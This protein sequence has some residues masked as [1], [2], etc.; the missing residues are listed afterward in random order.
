MAPVHVAGHIDSDR[1][2]HHPAHEVGLGGK[3]HTDTV[4]HGEKASVG[5]GT[6][7]RTTSTN[8]G[9]WRSPSRNPSG[10]ERRMPSRRPRGRGDKEA[11][12][13]DTLVLA[14][15]G[16]GGGRVGGCPAGCLGRIG[17]C[18]RAFPR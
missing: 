7:W 12:D 5:G 17:G 14:S 16:V 13:D 18:E 15:A 11:K 6:G 1:A 2:Q 10:A 3:A 8:S 4:V 9:R